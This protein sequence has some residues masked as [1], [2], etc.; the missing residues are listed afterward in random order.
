MTSRLGTG[1]LVTFFYSVAKS[2]ACYGKYSG[3]E[4]R[5]PSKIIN[6]RHKRRSGRHTLARKKRRKKKLSLLWKELLTNG[7]RLNYLEGWVAK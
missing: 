1:K 2:A 5:H 4:S 6:G 3:F 7:S